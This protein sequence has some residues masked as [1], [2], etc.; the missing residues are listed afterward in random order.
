VKHIHILFTEIANS[1]LKAYAHHDLKVN[2]KK[3]I[4]LLLVL[5][6]LFVLCKRKVMR[7]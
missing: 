4:S 2:R 3:I 7:C 5:K 6:T 1:L